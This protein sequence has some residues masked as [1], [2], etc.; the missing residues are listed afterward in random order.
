M[1]L[2][3]NY[4]IF[5]K[6]PITFT[7]W[8]SLSGIVGL[9]YN[10][11]KSWTGRFY[12]E[13]WIV[14]V[15]DRCWVPNGYSAPYSW[16][17]PPKTGGLWSN[18]WAKWA[19]SFTWF[20]ALWVNI[21]STIEW[22]GEI[23]DA[24]L[25]LILSAVATLSGIGWL[26]ADVV[27]SLNAAA[28]LAGNW[29]FTASLGALAGAVATLSGTGTLT[30]DTIANASLSADIYVNQSQASV[31]ELVYWVWNALAANYNTSGTMGEAAQAAWSG[32]WGWLTPTQA[33][34]LANTIKHW[35]LILHLGKKISTIL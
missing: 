10:W 21:E 1:A 25:W 32:S 26:S 18:V 29:D 30:S 31:Q 22:L 2:L 35:D 28:T 5:N 13:N 9:R 27:G 11:N 8:D 33:T 16:K 14:T 20:G 7:W 24:N 19:G 12:G 34:Q 17:L 6:N 15:A 3:W 23:A 4:N